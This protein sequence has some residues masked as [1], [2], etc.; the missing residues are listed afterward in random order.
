MV[1]SNTKIVRFFFYNIHMDSYSFKNV[2]G[3]KID[4]AIASKVNVA[5]KSYN[6]VSNR[7]GDIEKWAG[8]PNRNCSDFF[9]AHRAAIQ[10]HMGYEQ[11]FVAW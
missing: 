9:V 1:L 3:L 7:N 2:Y 10:Y 11:S 6:L 8:P 5:K 4:P